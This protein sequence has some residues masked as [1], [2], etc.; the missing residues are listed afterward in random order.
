MTDIT[1]ILT[2]QQAYDLIVKHWNSI[3]DP[4]L[5]TKLKALHASM[6]EFQEAY[7]G[8]YEDNGLM[9]DMNL[10]ED[11]LK[12]LIHKCTLYEFFPKSR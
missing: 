8:G 6:Q 12:K 3:F 1:D 10:R 4:A 11:M 7:G 2:E 9:M 5:Q